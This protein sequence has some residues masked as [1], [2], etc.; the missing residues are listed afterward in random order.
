MAREET[1]SERQPLQLAQIS[2][3]QLAEIAAVAVCRDGRGVGQM[4]PGVRFFESGELAEFATGE[5]E[6][7][8][9]VLA[10]AVFGSLQKPTIFGRNCASRKIFE[11]ERAADLDRRIEPSGGVND[12]V[13][14]ETRAGGN[15]EAVL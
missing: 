14:P 9:G 13:I 11:A 2:I 7:V 6:E 1:S 4:R 10:A 12:L 15:G 3:E 5:L 8:A